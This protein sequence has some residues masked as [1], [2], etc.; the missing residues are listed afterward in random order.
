[1]LD[2]ATST[3]LIKEHRKVSRGASRHGSTSAGTR[4]PAFLFVGLP[5][6]PVVSSR[7]VASIRFAIIVLPF[8][9]CEAAN[10]R[11]PSSITGRQA[12]GCVW[13]GFIGLCGWIRGFVP[14]VV[15]GTILEEWKQHG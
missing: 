11:I 6:S 10:R 3:A 12:G 13:L 1:M 9:Y 4:L 14:A 7:L 5:S 8:G 2:L 15:G